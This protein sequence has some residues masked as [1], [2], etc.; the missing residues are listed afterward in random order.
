MAKKHLS[1][2]YQVWVDARN[3]FHLSHAHIQ[4]AREL[5]MN[6]KKLG[7]KANH[8]QEPWKAPLPRFIEQLYLKF[9][10]DEVRILSQNTDY[11][12]DCS[13]DDP[14][15]VEDTKKVLRVMNFDSRFRIQIS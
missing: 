9:R 12:L 5:G 6:P 2:K 3:R 10:G 7:K 8:H 1:P 11:Q 15:E 4:M 13:R 14:Q